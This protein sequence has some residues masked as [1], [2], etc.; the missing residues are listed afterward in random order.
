MN[1]LVTTTINIPI[2]LKRYI[3]DFEKY[4]RVYEV[5]V[6]GDKKS[7]IGTKKYCA[8][9]ARTVYLDINDQKKMFSHLPIYEHIPFN[10]IGRRNL[11]YLYCLAKQYTKD[12]VII[13]IDD[14]NLL[15]QEDF[16]GHHSIKAAKGEVLKAREPAWHNALKKFYRERVFFRGFSP[17]HRDDNDDKRVKITKGT[18]KIAI[19]QG[20]WEENPDVDALDRL[21]GLRGDYLV[22]RKRS[23]ILAENVICPCDTQNTS[24]LNGFGLTAFLC[25][26]V[27]RYDDIFSSLITKRI[28]D[29][30][31]FGVSYGAPVVRQKRNVHDNFNDFLLEIH[32]MATV[33][34][35]VDVLWAMDIKADGLMQA[36]AQVGHELRHA[37]SFP[38]LPMGR[39]KRDWDVSQVGRGIG[40]WLDALEKLGVEEIR[41]NNKHNGKKR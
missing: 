37:M 13:T 32:G 3:K 24:Y 10:S 25:P 40:L 22:R 34:K 7:P 16:I 19:N 21:I 4:G 14:D 5:V 39:A 11:G 36:L 33:D 27:G 6:V 9:L 30:F 31:N 15:K 41:L 23:I 1:Y 12:D 17:W 38:S 20:L 2:A 29:H 28:A 35:L 26:Y 18:K 8:D